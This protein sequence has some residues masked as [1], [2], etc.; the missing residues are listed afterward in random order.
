MLGPMWMRP[1]RSAALRRRRGTT[2]ARAARSSPS[3]RCPASG[4]CGACVRNPGSSSTG[5]TR[6]SSVRRGSALEITASAGISVPSASTT[7]AAR[8]SRTRMRATRRAGADLRAGLARGV[9]HRRGQRAGTA[10]DRHAAAA[11]RRIGGGVRAAAPR[12]CRPTT[13]P[14]RCRRCRAP[15]RPPAADR[16]RTT[17]RRDRRPPSAPSAAAGTPSV[18]PSAR[19]RRPVL[20]SSHSSPRAGAVDRRRRHLE[21][22]PRKAPS[23]CSVAAELGIARRRPSPRTARMASAVRAR[24]VEKTSARPSGD[25]ATSRG[26]GRTNSTRRASCM[27]RTIDGRSGPIACASGAAVAGRDLLGDRRAADHVPPLEHER[28]QPRLREIER[29]DEAVVAGADD[30]GHGTGSQ[31]S[32][33]G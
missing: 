2:A 31:E 11:G 28:P 24:S 27:S 16:S 1:R 5:S 32:G 29:R 6:P 26:S 22:P 20:S 7:P 19:K 14:A 8:P 15:R 21:Q 3:R 18:R 17:R 4:S 13:D 25:S 30:D 9:G 33:A 23:R 10:L 12:R